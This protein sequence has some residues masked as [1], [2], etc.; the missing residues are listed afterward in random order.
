MLMA[1]VVKAQ[2]IDPG[3]EDTAAEPAYDP[4]YDAIAHTIRPST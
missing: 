3:D 2:P 4:R 1:A